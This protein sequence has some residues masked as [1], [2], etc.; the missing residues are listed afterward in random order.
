MMDDDVRNIFA[1]NSVLESRKVKVLH[2]ENGKIGVRV[3][4]DSM[5][6]IWLKRGPKAEKKTKGK[7]E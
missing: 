1:I 7:S 4:M 5:M 3:L 6:H 2:A